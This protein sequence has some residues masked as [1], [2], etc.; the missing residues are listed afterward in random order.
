MSQLMAALGTTGLLTQGTLPAGVT[1][2]A[3]VGVGASEMAHTTLA[4]GVFH[5]V[6]KVPEFACII[7]SMHRMRHTYQQLCLCSVCM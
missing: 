4:G 1:P 2:Q 7:T 3:G 6:L 5:T